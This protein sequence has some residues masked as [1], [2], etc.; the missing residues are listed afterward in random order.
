MA[1]FLSDE[2]FAAAVPATSR[3]PEPDALVI[4]QVVTGTPDGDVRY[5]VLADST[6]AWIDHGGRDGRDGPEPHLTITCNW[7]TATEVARGRLST[8]R[9]LMEGKL[10]I[11]GG[12]RDLAPRT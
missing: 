10:R 1:R 12:V 7:S 6:G 8:Q 2:W 5:L 11:R 3:S 9:A 4:E